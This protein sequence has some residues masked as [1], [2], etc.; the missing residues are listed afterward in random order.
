MVLYGLATCSRLVVLSASPLRRTFDAQMHGGHQEREEDVEQ[1]L[2]GGPE[3]DSNAPLLPN[4]ANSVGPCETPQQTSQKEDRTLLGLALYGISSLFLATVLMCSKLLS[5]AP[6]MFMC[7]YFWNSW[8]TFFF[9][10]PCCFV[11]Y[12]PSD[13]G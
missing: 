9:L 3:D 13:I 7:Q 4:G 6:S 11:W 12:P 2:V 1:G 8:S 5:A 10:S